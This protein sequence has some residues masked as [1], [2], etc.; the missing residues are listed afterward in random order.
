MKCPN[1]RVEN[2]EENRFC[3]ECGTKLLLS[4][5]QCQSEVL[6]GDKFCGQC[7]HKLEE[8]EKAGGIPETEGERKYVTVVFSDLSGYT[9]MSEKLDPE[10]VKEIMSRIFGEI[11]QVVTKYEGFIEKFVGD[12]VM[13]LFGIPKSHEDDPVR[14]IRAAREIHDRIEAL[15]PEIEKRIGQPLS[16]HTGINTGLVVTGEIDRQKGIHG[17]AGDTVNLASRLEDLAKRGEILV[18]NDTRRQA[19]GYFIFESMEPVT[20]KGKSEPVQVFR[21]LGPKKRPL[22]THRLSGLRADLIGR[23]VELAELKDAVDGLKQGK[24]KIFSIC[25]DA[26]T[27]KSRLVEEFKATLDLDQIQWFEGH[28]YP[29]SQNTPYFPLIDLLNGVFQIDEDDP[30]EKIRSKIE[31]GIRRLVRDPNDII[32][33]VGSLYSLDYPETGDVHP[34]FWKSRLQQSVLKVLVGLAKRRPTVFFLEDLH[35][36]DISFVDL[37]RKACL[38]IPQPA[39]VLCVY[40]PTFSLFTG[41]QLVS[42]KDIYREIRLQ[43]LPLS[44]AQQMLASLLKTESIPADLARLVQYKTEGNPFYLEEL[45]NSLIESEVLVKDNGTWKITKPIGELDISSSIYG[46]ISG[47]LDRLERQTKRVLQ[48]ASVIGRAFLYDIVKKITEVRDRVDSCL[49]ALERLDIIRARSLDPDLEYMFKH[50]LTQEVVYNGLLKKERQEIHEQIGLVMESL[51][52]E[53]ISEF[54]E[55]L[56]FHFSKGRSANKAVDYLVKAGEKSLARYSVQEAHEYYKQAYKLLVSKAESIEEDRRRL[57]D[58]LNSWA[59]VYYYLGEAKEFIDLFKTHM[60]LADSLDDK[61]RRGMFYAWLGI[62]LWLEGRS[63][64]SYEYLRIGLELGEASGDQKVEGYACTWLTWACA[65]LGLFDEG[66]EYGKRA[67]RIARSF[68]SDQYL[69]FKSLG[70]IS[71]CNLFKGQVKELLQ[72]SQSLL[73][74]GE[75]TSNSRSNVFGHWVDS[76]GHLMIGDYEAGIRSCEKAVEAALDPFYAIFPLVGLGTACVFNEQFQKAEEVLQ[77]ALVFGEKHGIG[78]LLALANML[79]GTILIAK[80]Q[81]KHGL[82]IF[83]GAQNTLFVNN[84][85]TWYALSEFVLGMVYARMATGP[86]PSLGIMAKNIGFLVKTAPFSAGE[87]EQHFLGAID[88]L[89]EIGAKGYL[90]LACLQLGLFYRVRKKADL[91]R[92]YLSEAAKI[93]KECDARIYLQ[94]AKEALSSIQAQES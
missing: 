11:A 92:K 87:A 58:L 83:K 47:R 19:E 12:A 36:A 65:E 68:P 81:M 63:R 54:Y 44:D 22:T 52:R 40:R 48:E 50:P 35:W 59:Y 23:D 18:G 70:G 7:G 24:G 82:K 88:L 78:E 16:M 28:A 69:F 17:V 72:A 43:D 2:P 21:V 39:I 3:R 31:S 32:P 8:V 80:G 45:V 74:Y 91:A 27:G 77:E 25:G 62:A 13:A 53:R 61:A 26:G 51:F 56:A 37:L 20:V 73:D 66:I 41:H 34:E 49:N 86:L 4:C 15:S 76:W 38:E 85:R 90:G 6:T 84:R 67:Q 42:V 10:E 55:T 60:D 57:I 5:P 75:R 71:Y 79:I 14:A 29:Y 93:C 33:Y 30:P 1:C 94:Q 46:I 9:S 89:R 64:D